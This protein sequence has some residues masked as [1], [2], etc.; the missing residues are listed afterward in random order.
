M[1][2]RPLLVLS[3][4]VLV[5]CETASHPSTLTAAT[6][7]D[8][9]AVTDLN[10]PTVDCFKSFARYDCESCGITYYDAQINCAGSFAYISFSSK[11]PYQPT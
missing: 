1:N 9:V 4:T 6:S 7:I 3:L 5:G 11:G 2:V 10:L 8:V